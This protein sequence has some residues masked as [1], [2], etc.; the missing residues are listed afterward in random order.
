MKNRD[1]C[2][3]LELA[4]TF[5]LVVYWIGARSLKQVTLTTTVSFAMSAFDQ[6]E[7]FMSSS[8]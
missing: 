1:R 7:V 3:W 4:V 5:W 2:R 6:I 8:V